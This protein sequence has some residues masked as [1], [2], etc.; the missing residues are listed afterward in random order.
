MWSQEIWGLRFSSG[1][2]VDLEV[3]GWKT[4]QILPDLVCSSI[5][6]LSPRATLGSINVWSLIWTFL[7]L[8]SRKQLL[9]SIHLFKVQWNLTIPVAYG[10]GISGWNREVAALLRWELIGCNNEVT[11][12]QSDHYYNNDVPIILL[13]WSHLQFW[14]SLHWRFYLL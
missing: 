14:M 6:H 13:V 11:A 7:S 5:F 9:Q 10:L 2:S 12:L 4:E 8:Q 1:A 3:A